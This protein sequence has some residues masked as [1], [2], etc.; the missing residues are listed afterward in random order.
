MK[1][2]CYAIIP[3]NVRYDKNLT[4]GTKLLYAELAAAT[5]FDGTV[6]EDVKYL[7]DV[8]DCDR[9]T[10]YRYVNQL[11]NGGYIQK[12]G[13]VIKLPLGFESLS[14]K[15]VEPTIPDDLKEYIALFLRRFEEGL[16][17]KLNK[18][19]LYY[20]TIFERLATFS[21]NELSLALENRI[22]FVMGSEWHQKEENRPNACDITLL[23]RDNSTVLKW[24]NMK[25]ERTNVEL[26]PFNFS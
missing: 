10:Y 14:Q 17:T 8:L 22:A 11:I 15:T 18:P 19:E 21:Q 13:N 2:N 9:R 3:A 5:S 12:E 1:L 16:H 23:I 4:H 26:K 24:L 20:Q 25:N 7:C 6:C